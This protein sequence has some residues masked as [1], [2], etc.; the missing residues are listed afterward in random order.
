MC[1][2]KI[3]LKIKQNSKNIRFTVEDTGIGMND[4]EILRYHKYNIVGRLNNF[5]NQGLTQPQKISKNTP[6]FGLGLFVS[7]QLA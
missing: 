6:G 7:N 4:M 5:L 1:K 3:L 2:G